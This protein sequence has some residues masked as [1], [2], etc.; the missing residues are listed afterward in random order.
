MILPFM[1]TVSESENATVDM[2]CLYRWKTLADDITSEL[3][4][5]PHT[6]YAE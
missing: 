5:M 2:Y 3:N 6:K 4:I 1:E